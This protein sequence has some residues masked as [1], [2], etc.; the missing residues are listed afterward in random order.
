MDDASG[1][2]SKISTS[3][4]T[5]DFPGTVEHGQISIRS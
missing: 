1:W 3:P 2:D 5:M 4:L